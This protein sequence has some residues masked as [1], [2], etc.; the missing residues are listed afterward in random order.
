M[1]EAQLGRCVAGWCP[2]ATGV[3]GAAKLSGGAS[4][5]TWTFDIVRAS[6]T[7][8]AILRRAPPG[9]GA[10]PGRAAGLDAEATLLQLA[11]D[12]GLPS[13]RGTTDCFNIVPIRIKHKGTIIVRMI[14]RSDSRRTVVPAPGV[15]SLVIETIDHVPVRRRKGNMHA[16]LV[17]RAPTNPEERFRT[18]PETGE[19]SLPR[20]KAFDTQRPQRPLVEPS[21][22]FQIPNT[23]RH[24]IQHRWPPSTAGAIRRFA[25]RRPVHRLQNGIE[26]LLQR[27]APPGTG[28]GKDVKRVV[29]DCR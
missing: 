18:H 14:L 27:S 25:R 5:E 3:S 17:R 4:Q 8:G 7:I 16:R 13:P 29:A 12:A 6:G 22:P 1:I 9:Y 15:Q 21:G 10:S 11:H 20:I 19:T 24:V 26:T 23:D 2:G 28:M